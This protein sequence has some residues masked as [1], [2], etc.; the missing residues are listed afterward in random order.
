MF[1]PGCEGLPSGG[2]GNHGPGDPRGQDIQIRLGNRNQLLA[3]SCEG[4]DSQRW[5]TLIGPSLLSQDQR[6]FG[7]GDQ[8]RRDDASGCQDGYA[9]CRSS[10]YRA[11][12]RV[13]GGGRAQGCLHGSRKQDIEKAHPGYMGGLS[14]RVDRKW[15]R[16]SC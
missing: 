6:P 14:G 5:R 11:V 13:E 7:S 15:R 2:R 9:G 1:Y 8:E 16:K 4:R 12:H 3:T 10:G